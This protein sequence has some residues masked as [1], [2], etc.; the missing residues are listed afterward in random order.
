VYSLQLSCTWFGGGEGGEGQ[1]GWGADD[2]FAGGAGTDD[3]DGVVEGDDKGCEAFD[4]RDEALEGDE[5]DVGFGDGGGI[6]FVELVNAR[7][8][9]NFRLREG[10]CMNECM[11]IPLQL[12]TRPHNTQPRLTPHHPHNTTGSIRNHTRNSFHPIP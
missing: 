11:N 5:V 1:G 6:C 9:F 8:E 2:G 7:E 4:E 10:I 3:G 12:H